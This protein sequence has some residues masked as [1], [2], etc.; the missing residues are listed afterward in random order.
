MSTNQRNAG[1]DKYDIAILSALATNTRLTTVELASMVHLSRTAVSRRITALKRAQVLKDDAEVLC[2][3]SLGFGVRA[4]VEISIPS[5][6]AESLRK[7]LRVQPEVLT[8][9]VIAG[10][11]LLCL[12]VIAID[13]DH[14]H[15]FIKAL[16]KSGDTST[17]IIYTEEKSQLT[18]LERM[19]M[20]DEQADNAVVRV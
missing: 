17:K 20:L 6:T 1:L 11:G 18:L 10:D 19:R 14:L 3:E 15:R 13:M 4:A 16:Q 9:S 2:Y 8:I 7:T 12:D 5:Q